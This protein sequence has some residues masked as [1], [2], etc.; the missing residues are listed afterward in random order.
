M[1]TKLSD[2]NT[3][4]T[5]LRE[6]ESNNEQIQQNHF[7]DYLMIEE[8][9]NN[10]EKYRVWLN[11]P[12]NVKLGEPKWQIEY[13]GKSNGYTWKTISEGNR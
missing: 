11:H 7:G 8:E 5:E 13:F 6:A 2:F 4:L 1:K 3:S 12:E 10:N 9:G